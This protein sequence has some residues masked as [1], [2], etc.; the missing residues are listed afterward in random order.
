QPFGEIANRIWHAQ[1]HPLAVHNRHQSVFAIACGDWRVL[2]KPERIELVHPIV[3]ARYGAAGIGHA[4]ELRRWDSVECPP[5]G[6][7]LPCWIRTVER[8]FA[9][10][11]VETREMAAGEHRPHHAVR[12]DIQAA[13]REALYFSL[14]VVPG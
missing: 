13:R 6:A 4:L 7:V 5:F 2:S 12:V 11:P 1:R 9:V 3:I 8:P 14:R 10:P